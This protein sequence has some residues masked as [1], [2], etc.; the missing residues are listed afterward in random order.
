METIDV[1]DEQTIKAADGLA[2]GTCLSAEG[3]CGALIGGILAIGSVVGRSYPEFSLGKRKRRVFQI[4]KKLFDRFEKEYG[5]PLCK[6][7]QTQLFGKSYCLI[8]P[9]EYQAFE[10]AGAH[11]DKCPKVAGNVAAWTVEILIS[12]LDREKND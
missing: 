10:E 4:S 5:G 2:G 3:T 9:S 6:Q 8:D 12:L 11:V 1:G 7:V